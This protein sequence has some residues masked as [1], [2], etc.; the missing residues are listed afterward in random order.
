MIDRE[1]DDGARARPSGSEPVVPGDTTSRSVPSGEFAVDAR[2]RARELLLAIHG[3]V[4]MATAPLLQGALT[5]ATESGRSPVVLDLTDLEFIDASGI[6]VIVGARRLFGPRGD[7]R[8][9]FAA[10]LLRRMLTILDLDDLIEQDPSRD[11]TGAS[12]SAS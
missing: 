5:R 8:L 12:T 9:R 6:G 4:D 7:L 10:P 2:D 1:P 3:E 11:A